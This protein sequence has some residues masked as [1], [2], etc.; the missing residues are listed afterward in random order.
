MEVLI[1][2]HDGHFAFMFKFPMGA[3]ENIYVPEQGVKMTLKTFHQIVKLRE[4]TGSL[5]GSEA[6]NDKVGPK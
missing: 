6:S 4:E 3:I 1:D 2:Y 5:F